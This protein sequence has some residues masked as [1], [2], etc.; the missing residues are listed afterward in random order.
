MRLIPKIIN[1]LQELQINDDVKLISQ[2]VN[3]RYQVVN[4]Y[5]H[6]GKR[7]IGEAA[8][9]RADLAYLYIDNH[10]YTRRVLNHSG[11]V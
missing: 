9:L 3:S 11:A 6:S 10:D 5:V 1:P 4:T 8:L 7:Y 2:H